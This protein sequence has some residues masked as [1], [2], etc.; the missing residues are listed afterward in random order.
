[1]PSSLHAM[2]G[3]GDSIARGVVATVDGAGWL[4]LPG[5]LPMISPASLV[6]VASALQDS[7]AAVVQAFVDTHAAHPVGFTAQCREHLLALSGDSGARSVVQH[8][9][10]LGLWQ[11]LP[12]DDSGALQDVDT[13]ADLLAIA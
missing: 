5:D 11:A 1:M 10:A 9:K 4:V 8:F 7:H 6:A 2:L 12:I 3:M 13:L